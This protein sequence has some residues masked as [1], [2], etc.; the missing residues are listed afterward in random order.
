MFCEALY[1][2]VR[3]DDSDPLNINRMKHLGLLPISFLAS[4]LDIITGVGVAGPSLLTGAVYPEFLHFAKKQLRDGGKKLLSYPYSH[5][6]HV[7][8]L[9]TPI[10]FKK[11][12]FVFDF[13]KVQKIFENLVKYSNE[14]YTSRSFIKHHVLSRVPYVLVGLI[15]LVTRAVDGVIC[16]PAVTASIVTGGKFLRINN[17]AYRALLFPAVLSDFWCCTVKFFHPAVDINSKA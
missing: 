15:C 1:S 11:E 8:N 17:I 5:M 16:V 2:S 7:I 10:L 9:K 3:I 12:G 14:N 4:V 13:D 6:I